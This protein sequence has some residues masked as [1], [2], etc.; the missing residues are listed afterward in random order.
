MLLLG[1]ANHSLAERERIDAYSAAPLNLRLL[2]LDRDG[3][4]LDGSQSPHLARLP[5]GGASSHAEDA[6]GG[7]PSPA[8]DRDLRAAEGN[9]EA[10]LLDHC[11]DAR[12]EEHI[13][14]RIDYMLSGQVL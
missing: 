1:M 12:R 10:R 9:S 5:D 14:R 8:P 4:L 3:P 11:D 7:C 6:R 2:A 13:C